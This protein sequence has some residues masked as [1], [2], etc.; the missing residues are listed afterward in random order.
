MLV[1]KFYV[2]FVN[3]T[4]LLKPPAIRKIKFPLST[5]GEERVVERSNDRVSNRKA[6]I[7]VNAFRRLLTP[8]SLIRFSTLS[9]LRGKGVGNP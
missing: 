3:K 2:V 8:T 5:E 9:S 6:D 1:L 4:V 7:T